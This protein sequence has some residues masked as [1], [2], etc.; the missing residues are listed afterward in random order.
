M[1]TNQPKTGAN[2][3][4]QP[5]PPQAFAEWGVGQFA[6]VKPMT[7]ADQQLFGVFA[8]NGEQ[9]GVLQSYPVARA[10]VIQHDM[11]PVSVH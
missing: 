10:A 5:M 1:I 11:E 3:A 2:T 9:I 6:Y 8:A 4:Y 7:V